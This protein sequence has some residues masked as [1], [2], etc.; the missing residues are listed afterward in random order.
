[1]CVGEC[2]GCWRGEQVKAPSLHCQGG[3]GVQ[4]DHCSSQRTPAL[5]LRQLMDPTVVGAGPRSG[6]ARVR[7][8]EDCQSVPFNT[9]HC[10]AASS[11]TIP[12]LSTLRHPPQDLQLQQ[13]PAQL[14]PNQDQ[15]PRC[16]PSVS[17]ALLCSSHLTEICNLS[18]THKRCASPNVASVPLVSGECLIATLKICLA[19]C[20]YFGPRKGSTYPS[21]A[22]VLCSCSPAQEIGEL[23]PC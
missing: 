10:I 9:I 21:P 11:D 18:V 12:T 13:R 5:F 1:M 15:L 4:L 16:P 3:V 8:T 20:N 19:Q 17:S 6:Q 2:G 14:P 7:G 22:T 23:S